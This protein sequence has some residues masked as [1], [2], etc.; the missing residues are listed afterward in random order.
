MIQGGDPTGSGGGTAGY[1]FKEVTDLKFDKVVFWLW[2]TL[3]QRAIQL[4]NS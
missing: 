1:A 3:V 2:P 4:N